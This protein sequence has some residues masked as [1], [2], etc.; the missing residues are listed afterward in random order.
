MTDRRAAPG[1]IGHL[2]LADQAYDRLEGLI[3]TCALA[4][5]RYLAIQDLQTITG[6]SRTPVHQAVSRLAADTL[7]LMFYDAHT[8]K[9]MC[10]TTRV[11]LYYKK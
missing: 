8:I 6:N 4:P 11:I 9:I 3:V 7:I 5:G 10:I 1:R 2:N